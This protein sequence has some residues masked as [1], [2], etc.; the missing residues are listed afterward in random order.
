[1]L[2]INLLFFPELFQNFH[3]LFLKIHPILVFFLMFS[4]VCIMLIILILTN[5]RY[6]EIKEIAIASYITKHN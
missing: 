3:L 6:T 5:Q 2:I 1:M 4:Q